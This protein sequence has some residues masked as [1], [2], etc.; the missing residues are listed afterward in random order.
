VNC[1]TSALVTLLL[2][3]AAQV[4]P[5]GVAAVAIAIVVARRF[6]TALPWARLAAVIEIAF[7]AGMSAHCAGE[8]WWAMAFESPW[9]V[10]SR[11]LP[12]AAILTLLTGFFVAAGVEL[13]GIRLVERFR[14]LLF[15]RTLDERAG[16]A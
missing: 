3:A 13:F 12:A 7:L 9:E 1:A 6:R 4:F 14:R 16:G 5:V 8:E 10:A 2:A 15:S 11:H